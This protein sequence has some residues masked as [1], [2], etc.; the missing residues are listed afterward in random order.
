[1]LKKWRS[2]IY[3]KQY[4]TNNLNVQY[5]AGFPCYILFPPALLNRLL[6]LGCHL[7]ASYLVQQW[8]IV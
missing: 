1:M 7:K 3:V 4:L 2:N 6:R 8:I 5:N